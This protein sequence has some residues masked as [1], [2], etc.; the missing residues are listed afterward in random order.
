MVPLI[1]IL[2]PPYAKRTKSCRI[3]KRRWQEGMWRSR[4]VGCWNKSYVTI[5]GNFQE[6]IACL[7]MGRN[8][9][10]LVVTV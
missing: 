9:W 5:G 8:I 1:L 3:L 7:G 10:K 2:D 4:V 6:E